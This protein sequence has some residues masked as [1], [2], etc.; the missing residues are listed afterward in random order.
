MLVA[1]ALALACCAECRAWSLPDDLPAG[2]LRAPVA[3]HMRVNGLAIAVTALQSAADPG[4]SCQRIAL[5]WRLRGS[6]M[7]PRCERHGAWVVVARQIG[8]HQQSVQLAEHARG[9]RGYFSDLDLAIAPARLPRSPWPMPARAQLQNIVQS[10]DRTGVATQ[11]SLRLPLRAAPVQR[12][13]LAAARQHGWRTV[14]MSVAPDRSSLDT[15]AG[16]TIDFERAGVQLRVLLVAA[17]GGS[18]LLLF[19]RRRPGPGP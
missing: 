9:S 4:R 2:V 10:V 18:Q 17:P 3:E 6:A 7:P 13:L 11:F 16:R 12:Q 15:D 14:A 1:A 8:M 5:Q 19:E